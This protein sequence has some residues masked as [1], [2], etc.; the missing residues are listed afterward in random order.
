MVR[1]R[2]VVSLILV[3]GLVAARAAPTRAADPPNAGASEPIDQLP[4]KIAV[5]LAIEPEARVDERGRGRLLSAWQS[6]A[7]R[8]VGAPWDWTIAEEGGAIAAVPPESIKAEDFADVS[9][10]FDKVWS[11]RIGREPSGSGYALAGREFDTA[12]SRLGPLH[13]RPAPSIPDLPRALLEFS[14][15]VFSPLGLVGESSGG[16]VT[17]TVR[18]GSLEPASPFGNVVKAGSVFKPLRVHT[19]EQGKPR[20]LDVPFTYLRVEELD[21]AT[22]RCGIVSALRDPLTKRVAGRYTTLALGLN[23]GRSPMRFRF[24]T[25]P[26]KT[27]AAGYVLTARDVPEGLPREVGTTDREGRIALAP[28]FAEGLVV[29]RLLAGQVEPMVEFPAMPGDSDEERTI[30]F[31]PKPQTVTLEAQVESLRD[32]IIDLVATRARLEARLKA[33]ADGED[34]NG[35]EAVLKE[36]AALPKREPLA[37]KL[38]QLKEDAAQRQ[39]KSKTA[40]LT[41]TAQA[42]ITDVQ[43]LIDRYLEDD[44]FKAHAD[45]LANARAAPAAKKAGAAK[46]K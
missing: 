24:V 30:P 33:R 43:S 5:H 22:A 16:G 14:K 12:T 38:T 20:V 23:P 19:P 40:I 26:D 10:G 31:D 35:V 39:A 32:A 15:E 25:R 6:L 21:G 13:R 9:K 44:V 4:Y 2:P 29:L 11:I 17:I 27:P 37:A 34:W 45:S 1:A 46:A 28:G 18:G 7:R 41:K 42:E 36:F 3:F 8:F